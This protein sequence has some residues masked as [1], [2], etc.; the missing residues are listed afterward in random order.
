MTKDN[1]LAR[2]VAALFSSPRYSPLPERDLAKR[3]G[4]SSGQRGLLRTALRSL[5]TQ[6]RAA[7]LRGGRW[8]PAPVSAGQIA[9]TF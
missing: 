1:E 2:R 4:L 3:L 9:G 7:S 6:G 5:E 8:G